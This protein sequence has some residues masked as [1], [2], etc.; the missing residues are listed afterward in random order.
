MKAVTC[1]VCN[2]KGSLSA[3]IT[4]H[5]TFTDSCRGCAGKGWVEVGDD[6]LA[7]C[8]GLILYGIEL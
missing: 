3:D 6:P 1:P 5:G 8:P 7:Y 4:P 2:G